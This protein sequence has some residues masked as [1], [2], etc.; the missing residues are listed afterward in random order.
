MDGKEVTKES[1]RPYL[2]KAEFQSENREVKESF[3]NVINLDN[4][5]SMA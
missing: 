3:R 2:L 5:H 4:V 1:I